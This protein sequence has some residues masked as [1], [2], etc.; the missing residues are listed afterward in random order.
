LSPFHSFPD[1]ISA[2]IIEFPLSHRRLVAALLVAAH[3]AHPHLRKHTG[4]ITG[5]FMPF[6]PHTSA[7]LFVNFNKVA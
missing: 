6:V 4:N 2:L 7:L 3:H 5:R 1:L